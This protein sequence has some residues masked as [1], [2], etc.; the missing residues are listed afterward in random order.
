MQY[1]GEY[2]KLD[3]V[4]EEVSRGSMRAVVDREYAFEL[5]E[6]REAF[7]YLMAGHAAGKVIVNVIA[8]EK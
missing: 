8:N 5:A 7:T 1:S 2:A 4:D 3:W 6:V